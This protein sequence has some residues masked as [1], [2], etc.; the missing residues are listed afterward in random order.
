MRIKHPY[1]G[2]GPQF[3]ERMD[4]SRGNLPRELRDHWSGIALRQAGGAGPSRFDSVGKPNPRHDA[5]EA[6]FTQRALT[7][8]Q[9]ELV[10]TLVPPLEARKW[11][12]YTVQGNPGD[13]SFLWR[14]PTRTGIARF[15]TP[16][17]ARDLPA[18]GAYIEEI[19]T[20]YYTVGAMLQ[21]DYFEL[22]A[23]GAAA[24]NGQPFDFVKEKLIAALEANEKKLDLISAFGSAA[25]PSSDGI[26][27]DLDVGMTGLLNDTDASI[28]VT[29]YGIS[30]SRSWSQKTADEVLA[31]L[32]GIVS[33]Q[34]SSTYKVHCPTHIG[35]P[36]AQ[37][38][39]I[40]NRRMGDIGEHTILSFFVESQKK[41]GQPIEVFSWQYMQGAG[42]T[43][44]DLM[45]AFNRDT[46]MLRNPLST[47]KASLP[48]E[49][50][51]LTTEQ[52]VYSR[53]PG[54]IL[55]RP[56]SVTYGSYI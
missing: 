35:L 44:S 28:Y 32:F 48:P 37:Y 14:R 40:A 21:Y 22:L 10:P 15:F 25:P 42:A 41:I 17:G 53:T 16:G 9:E 54:L 56:L 3:I 46:R 51:G 18:V 24:A 49:T 31:D 12:P 2:D 13:A 23:I 38:Q 39:S 50:R 55:Y 33:Y 45:V 26:E 11:I 47:D 4:S 30:G 5:A 1:F 36:I 7:Y 34:I 29:P 52:I 43:G 19:N 20:P 8:I 27:Q 6:A